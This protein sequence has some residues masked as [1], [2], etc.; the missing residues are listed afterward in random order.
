MVPNQTIAI[1]RRCSPRSSPP[2]NGSASPD[3]DDSLHYFLTHSLPRS[4]MISDILRFFPSVIYFPITIH[5]PNSTSCQVTYD[6]YNYN[7]SANFSYYC[8][9]FFSL[10]SFPPPDTCPFYSLPFSFSALHPQIGLL[11]VFLTLLA[12]YRTGYKSCM[13]CLFQSCVDRAWVC[14]QATISYEEHIGDWS[15]GEYLCWYVQNTGTPTGLS[16]AY[17]LIGRSV[18]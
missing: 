9:C 16:A 10:F 3:L 15:S 1:P 11:K 17:E 5:V 13:I 4:P 7:L 2:R 6:Y 12:Q 8:F 14:N 18:H